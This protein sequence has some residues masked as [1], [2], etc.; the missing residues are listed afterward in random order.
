MVYK[1]VFYSHP[2]K[3][4]MPVRLETLPGAAKKMLVRI[5]DPRFFLHNGLDFQSIKEAYQVNRRLGY[6]YRGA[7][8]LP[9]QLARTLFLIPKKWYFRKALEALIALE[10]NLLVPKERIIELYLNSAEWGKGIFGI[11]AASWHYYQ[12]PASKLSKDQLARL[13]TI[14][15]SPIRYQPKNFHKR[16]ALLERYTYLSKF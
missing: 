3:P 9:Q 11:G 5:E 2:V 8:T 1:M 12:R 7:S 16:K 15:A 14:L 6:A 10:M 4:S 13:I